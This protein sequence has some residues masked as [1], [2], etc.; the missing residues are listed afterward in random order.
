MRESIVFNSAPPQSPNQKVYCYKYTE[1][2][3]WKIYTEQSI[4]SGNAWAFVAYRTNVDLL[5]KKVET[6]QKC[7]VVTESEILCKASV[8]R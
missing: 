3:A 5:V 2:R 8:E 7:V 4:I 6:F 1:R